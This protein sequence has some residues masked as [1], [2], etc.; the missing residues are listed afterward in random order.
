LRNGFGG[1]ALI[2]NNTANLCFVVR[3]RRMRKLGGWLE[4]LSA[5]FNEVPSVARI[6]NGATQCWPR[7]LAISPIPY[8]YIAKSSGGIWRLGDQA[9]VIPSFTGDGMSIALHTA[10]L[11]SEMFLSGKTPDEYLDCLQTQLHFGMHFA[12][13]LSR[14]MVTSTGR[15]LAP[16]FL[17]LVPGAIGWIANHTRIPARL[18]QTTGLARSTPGDHLPASTG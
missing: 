7:P 3:Q 11:A 6:L 17:S 16:A 1:L 14:M 13:T 15:L 12:T 8:G 9:A 2:E 18:L 10:E 5:V 4:L